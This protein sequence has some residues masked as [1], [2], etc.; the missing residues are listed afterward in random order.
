MA[1]RKRAI[2]PLI[3]MLLL[4][5]GGCLPIIVRAPGSRDP[6]KDLDVQTVASVTDGEREKAINNSVLQINGVGLVTG[7]GG[8]G[9]CPQGMYREMLEKELRKQKIERIREILDNPD[10]ALVLVSATL[11]SGMRKGEPVDITITLPPNSRAT[12]LRGGRLW[13]CNL[14]NFELVRT[15]ASD[16]TAAENKL[17]SGDVL[18]RAGYQPGNPANDGRLLVGLQDP[19]GPADLKQAAMWEGGIVLV[20]R[21]YYFVMKRDDKSAHIANAVAE[22]L[23]GLFREDADKI[24]LQNER[25]RK[26]NDV[27]LRLNQKFDGGRGQV[28]KPSRES[29]AL[30]VPFA[31]CL[32][33]E[34]YLRV[35]RLVPLRQTPEQ[36]TRYREKVGQ[37]LLDPKDTLRAALR[38]EALGQDSIE[39]LKAAV[40]IEK[41]RPLVNLASH[42][43]ENH[44]LVRFAAAESLAYLGST[45]AVN[46]LAFLAEK[47][48]ELRFWCLLAMANLNESVCRTRLTE[49]LEQSDAELRYGAFVALRQLN[50]IEGND[51]DPSLGG[52]RLG[53]FWLH[54]VAP[55]SPPLVHLSMSRREE[56]VIFGNGVRLQTPV[57]ISAGTEF[58]I[59]AAGPDA[60]EC[61]VSRVPLREERKQLQA[62]MEID[63]ILWKMA[64]LGAQYP[65]VVD[66][67]RK[68]EN[69]GCLSC[70]L[71]IDA[72]PEQVS[73][74]ILAEAG[75]D[76]KFLRD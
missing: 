65:D 5:L 22:R 45:A 12:S 53:A 70:P 75:R 4:V 51:R 72:I 39:M 46:E 59:T 30:S 47:H 64:E 67:L 15:T 63:D 35:A 24:R 3:G 21:P 42:Y 74:E 73:V 37:M 25:F 32:N 11:K 44:P 13:D 69:R 48:R 58:T 31:Y 52:Q 33:P 60:T 26:Q 14:R 2:W 8:S 23:N 62:A 10:N 76:A 7:L 49:L 71:R 16:F 36:L 40:L 41:P 56:I 34:R 17:L 1:G 50:R 19:K 29:I 61:T 9:D 57:A 54:R 18:A 6:D 28:A 27:A 43:E 20:D 66:F 38:L 55:G 68:A